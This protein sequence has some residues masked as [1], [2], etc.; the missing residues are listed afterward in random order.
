ME[1][2]QSELLRV[3]GLLAEDLPG[4]DWVALVDHQ[5]LVVACVP[6][7]PAVE[8]ERIS[9]MTAA[10]FSMGERVLGEVEGG[11]LRYASVAGSARQY[12]LVVLGRDNLLSIGLNPDL[13]A[14]VTFGP[15]SRWV[16]E[17]MRA[18]KKRFA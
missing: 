12:L 17:L 11:D 7:S 9:A 10:L 18:L 14:Q 5:G 16:P 13:P 2:R 3:L 6:S 4:P 8:E 1:T 15:L